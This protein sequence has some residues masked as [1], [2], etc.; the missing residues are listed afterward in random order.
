MS[1]VH[2]RHAIVDS[3]GGM[4]ANRSSASHRG[5]LPQQAEG[6]GRSRGARGQTI[7][8]FAFAVPVILLIFLGIT[9]FG[10][11]ILYYNTLSNAAREGARVG[12]VQN[13]SGDGWGAYGN[14]V[15]TYT[16]LQDS[17]GLSA[18]FTRWAALEPPGFCPTSAGVT[19]DDETIVSQIVRRSSALGISSIKKVQIDAPGGTGRYLRAPLTVLV[20][21]DY[22]PV[23]SFI[24]GGQTVTL[25][26]SATMRIE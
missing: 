19:I 15:G 22:T 5:V 24:I 13:W 3:H 18:D 26:A 7:V 1:F 6:C 11:A 10:R 14:C 17:G 25:R 8:E 16:N 4:L 2:H 20:E 21:Y 9:D 23:T 12:I